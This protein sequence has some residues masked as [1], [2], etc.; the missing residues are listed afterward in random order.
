MQYTRKRGFS[1]N[2][3]KFL[4][5]FAYKLQSLGMKNENFKN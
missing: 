2:I 1:F 5:K 4:Q 3:S